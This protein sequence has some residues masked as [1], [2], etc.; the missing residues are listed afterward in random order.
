MPLYEHV[1]LA[2]QDITTQQVDSLINDMQEILKKNGGQVCK[3]EVWGLRNLAY[4]IKKYRK[5]Q[6]ALLNIDAPVS[7]ISELERQLRLN[8]NVIRFL[9][10]KVDQHE[11]GPSIMLQKRDRDE[12]RK[13][14]RD[15]QDGE[16]EQSASDTNVAQSTEEPDELKG[17]DAPDESTVSESNEQDATA[18]G[19][20]ADSATVETEATDSTTTK[21]VKTDS[22]SENDKIAK[23]ES[24]SETKEAK[25]DDSPKDLTE[26]SEKGKENG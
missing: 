2:R 14:E 25:Q 6:Y 11:D 12:K 15:S 9:T 7:A 21:D 1:L 4:K 22:A 24:D 17:V 16:T 13:K 19:K 3:S 8:D 5:A 26:D 10:I 20:E 23:D 18:E